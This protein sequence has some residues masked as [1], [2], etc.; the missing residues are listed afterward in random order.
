MR[1]SHD[2]RFFPSVFVKVLSNWQFLNISISWRLPCLGTMHVFILL[3]FAHLSFLLSHR[4]MLFI[5]LHSFLEVGWSDNVPGNG[6]D[7]GVEGCLFIDFWYFLPLVLSVLVEFLEDIMAALVE[8]PFFEFAPSSLP[9]KR[10]FILKCANVDTWGEGKD[11]F[12]CLFLLAFVSGFVVVGWT[13]SRERPLAGNSSWMLIDSGDKGLLFLLQV[14]LILLLLWDPQFVSFLKKTSFLI[15]IELGVAVDSFF[16]ETSSAFLSWNSWVS[17]KNWTWVCNCVLFQQGLFLVAFLRVCNGFGDAL[18]EEDDHARVKV[19]LLAELW[20]Y[21][22]WGV[23]RVR[24]EV[25]L[26]PVLEFDLELQ[27][28]CGGVLGGRGMGLR[29]VENLV[30]ESWAEMLVLMGLHV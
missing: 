26:P 22:Q 30:V 18:G 12:L 6:V 28:G 20:G 3:S 23:M 2:N 27:C 16:A 29:L 4:V 11:N 5:F 25:D 15:Q 19:V 7:E 14:F 21:F 10:V 1:F 13:Q 8:I 24:V 17:D 9:K